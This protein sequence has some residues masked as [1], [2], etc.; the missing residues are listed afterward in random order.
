MRRALTLV[1][2]LVV[3]CAASPATTTG[4][5]ASSSATPATPRSV[6]VSSDGAPFLELHDE[7][8][9]LVDSNAPPPMTR[10]PPHPFLRG[11]C[12]GGKPSLCSRAKAA[13][14]AS[15]S[16]D[17]VLQRLRRDGFTVEPR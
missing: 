12:F 15:R 10:I 1:S 11:S 8:G 9:P 14:D 2:L 17:E 6:R 13:I 16:F 3:S 4:A 5:P 7:P